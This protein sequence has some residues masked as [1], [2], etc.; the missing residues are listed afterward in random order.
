MAL[1]LKNGC[2]FVESAP[3]G[4]FRFSGP[5]HLRYLHNR[6]TQ[7][8]KGL[9]FGTCARSLCLSPNGRI[10]GEFLVIKDE[11]SIDLVTGKLVSKDFFSEI[12]SS[13]LQFKVADQ[14]ECQDL[15]EGM[16]Q[17]TLIG[18]GLSSLAVILG[19]ELQGKEKFSHFIK[20]FDGAS[21]RFIT[22]SVLGLDAV[23]IIGPQDPINQLKTMSSMF[24][25]QELDS[26][27]AELLRVLDRRW[28][29]GVDVDDKT[30]AAEVNLDELVSFK[31]G[32]YPG[33]EVVEMSISRGRPNR[34]LE[35]LTAESKIA[36]GSEIKVGDKTA[37]SISSSIYLAEVA[38]S[39]FL[40]KVKTEFLTSTELMV[41]EYSCRIVTAEESK[42]SV[43]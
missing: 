3:I 13:I 10:Q 5:D 29:F 26:L 31:K 17:I 40:S 18:S 7:D 1:N 20:E 9:T 28:R 6:L 16:T 41:D 11:N 8:I 19:V 32:C 4:H 25:V 14:L 30:L 2:F 43:A 24:G 38:R 36:V 21:L 23:E 35:L 27:S 33:Q 37:G 12:K 15:S 39:F 22:N 34:S 42:L